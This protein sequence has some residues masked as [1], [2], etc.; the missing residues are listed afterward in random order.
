VHQSG[1]Y[2]TVES[3]VGQGTRMRLH[4]PRWDGAPDADTSIVGLPSVAPA[5]KDKQIV[6]L[7]EDEAPVL[8]LAARALARDGWSILTAPDG[9]AALALMEAQAPTV[10]AVVT[11]MMMPGI[12][13][14]TLVR[15]L[16]DLPGLA[17]LPAILVSGYAEASLREGAVMPGTVFIS[18]PYNMKALAARLGELLCVPASG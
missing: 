16:R 4:L 7:V 3:V 8:R 10:S 15:R 6:L 17:S 18:K 13:G 14:A 5:N 12:D 1:G 11:D 9:E 2:L